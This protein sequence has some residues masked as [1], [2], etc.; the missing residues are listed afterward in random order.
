[1]S[2][3]LRP[4]SSSKMSRYRASLAEAR[5]K[6]R[7]GG[8]KKRGNYNTET[9]SNVRERGKKRP[10]MNHDTKRPYALNVQF[11]IRFFGTL[12]HA[13][14]H[15]PEKPAKRW[16]Q[17]EQRWEAIFPRHRRLTMKVYERRRSYM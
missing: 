10:F 6:V 4:D 13:T 12:H 16:K 14:G 9:Y 8:K 1:M 2:L 3:Y 5:L 15:A 11:K 7:V 17:A